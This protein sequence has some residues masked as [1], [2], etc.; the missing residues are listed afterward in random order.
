MPISGQL[1]QRLSR[2]V[3]SQVVKHA[4]LGVQLARQLPLLVQV[5]DLLVE[6]VESV[7][8]GAFLIQLRVALLFRLQQL[9]PL[10]HE[11]H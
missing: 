8:Q 7:L 9:L 4:L 6:V 2:Y 10:F 1:L 11:L 3:F 5:F